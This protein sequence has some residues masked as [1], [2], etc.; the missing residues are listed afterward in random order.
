MKHLAVGTDHIKIVRDI[1][2]V[3]GSRVVVEKLECPTKNHE[4]VL[5]ERATRESAC[6]HRTMIGSVRITVVKNIIQRNGQG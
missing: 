4:R 2:G 3:W 5:T 1:F 6:E